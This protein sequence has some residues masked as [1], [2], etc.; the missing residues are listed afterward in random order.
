MEWTISYEP[1][2]QI[3][4]IQTQGIADEAGSLD[5]AKSISKSMREYKATRCLIDHRG[6][7]SVTGN[8]IRLYNRPKI[9]RGIGVPN[10]IK[11]AQVVLLDHRAHFGFLETVCRN[12]GF[13]FCVFNKR[14]P[15]MEWLIK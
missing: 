3:V 9:L 5:M 10:N 13:D 8:V 6:I 7:S 14:E 12:N 2:H 1:D 4:V 15:A 11:I